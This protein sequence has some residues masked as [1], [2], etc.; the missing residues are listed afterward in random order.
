MWEQSAIRTAAAACT[1]CLISAHSIRCRIFAWLALNAHA[2]G[3]AE[4][5]AVYRT[6]FKNACKVMQDTATRKKEELQK[7]ID[8]ATGNR[9]AMI[10]GPKFEKHQFFWPRE[11]KTMPSP[12]PTYLLRPEDMSSTNSIPCWFIED[13]VTKRFIAWPANSWVPT[14]FLGMQIR[15]EKDPPAEAKSTLEKIQKDCRQY[16]LFAT[17]PLQ[18]IMQSWDTAS[19]QVQDYIKPCMDEKYVPKQTVSAPSIYLIITNGL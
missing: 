13:S 2:N 19:N 6:S 4:S 17:W 15:W 10:S 1:S 3:Q 12:I 9:V 11:W 18:V 5:A 8:A 14:T 7:M 16:C